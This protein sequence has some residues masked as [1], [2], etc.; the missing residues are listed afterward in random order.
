M[1]SVQTDLLLR[2]A[3]ANAPAV[4]ATLT[5][6]P[7]QWRLALLS[8]TAQGVWARQLDGSARE[9]DGL[10]GSSSTVG[11]FFVSPDGPAAFTS[12]ILGRGSRHDADAHAAA[13]ELLLRAPEKLH[14]FDRRQEPRVLVPDGLKLHIRLFRRP[15]R[16]EAREIL[17]KA[18]DLGGYGAG[19][20][21]PYDRSLL[22]MKVGEP[23]R[24]TIFF[25]GQ[26]IALDGTLRWVRPNAARLLWLGV[27]FDA[28][29]PAA[30]AAVREIVEELAKLA[31]RLRPTDQAA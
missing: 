6:P 12:A 21:H 29:E 20:V 13:R 9:L 18:W 14:T 16:G 1:N 31:D 17:A 15:A 23:V 11:I 28:A 8:C 2:S 25:R 24:T 26:T 4:L 3:S 7:R 22:A 10:V 5:H 30:L 19:F 27:R